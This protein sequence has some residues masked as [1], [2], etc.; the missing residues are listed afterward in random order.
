VAIYSPGILDMNFYSDTINALNG[1]GTVDMTGGS[2]STLTVGNNGNSGTFSG[3]IQNT[4][5]TMNLSKAGNGTE[6]LTASNSYAGT[7]TINAGT[8]RAS[9][10]YALGASAVVINNGALDVATPRLYLNSLA[11]TGGTVINNG[12]ASTNTLVVQGSNTTT[13]AGSIVDGTSGKMSL[14]MLAGT[15]RL[16]AANTFTN[17]TT[18]G[19]GATLQLGNSPASLAGFVIASNSATLGLAGGSAIPGT[20][21]SITTVDGASVLFTSIAEGNTWGGQ[22]IG[23]ATATN[24][25]T[26]AC[27]LGGAL[28]LSNF[29]GVVQIAMDNASNPN[30]RFNTAVGGGDNTTFEFQSGRQDGRHQRWRRNLRD[31]RSR[32][33]GADR[34]LADWRQERG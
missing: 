34:H 27:T 23:S 33:R 1:N 22:F 12:A 28:S 19:S 32:D 21:A 15:M 30:F 16:N 6:T 18:V 20:P 3:I 7:T 14:L 26:G 11:G 25:F 29:L 31:R 2:T 10:P 24:R 8:L 4:T 13:F 9:N 17:G 5:G